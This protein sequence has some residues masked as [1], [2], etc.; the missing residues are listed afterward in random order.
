M[1]ACLLRRILPFV[2]WGTAVV[3]CADQHAPSSRDL[4][5]EEIQ[6]KHSVIKRVLNLDENV[7]GGNVSEAAQQRLL[8][9]YR[10]DIHPLD[11]AYHFAD[12]NRDAISEG[13]IFAKP[14]IL[15]LGPWSTGK[16]TMI[17]YL[18]G[19]DKDSPSKLRTGAEPTT[20]DFTVLTHGPNHRIIKGIQLVSDKTKH[21]SPLQKFGLDFLERFQ[22]VELPSPLLER[23]TLVDTPGIIE[24]KKQQTRGYPFNDVCQW[25][26]DRAQLIFLIFDPTKLDIGSE[27]EVLF[28]QLKGHEA[29]LRLILN[30]ADTVT[31]QEL[32]RVYG[33]LFWSLAPLVH[34][35]EPPRVYIGSMWSQPYR[36]GTMHSVFRDEEISL[37]S[38]MHQIIRYQLEHKIAAT[39]RH[40]FLVRLHA[41][42]VD[43]YLNA[44]NNNR[45]IVFGDNSQL[46]RDIVADPKK[47]G[48]FNKLRQ[49]SDISVHD[50]PTAQMYQDFFYLNNLSNF[51]SLSEFCSFW[52]GQCAMDRLVKAINNGLPNLL[53][54]LRS[55]NVTT[56]QCSR[57]SGKC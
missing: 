6:T 37:L 41:L 35:V 50:L 22:G 16:S 5:A 10:E 44:Y 26:I 39:R 21:Y 30:K 40:A 46:W 43:C 56:G 17:N 18:L 14:M 33:A 29:K 47:Y 20:S 34:E 53:T 28:K 1:A 27:L 12:L 9:I 31:P 15:F 13:E 4:R 8:Q 57:D 55:G 49:H 24:N 36:P 19:T 48:I 32:M 25:F 45:G 38:D 7:T 3:L 52:S 2:L 11:E 23:V 54:D 51:K 42:T